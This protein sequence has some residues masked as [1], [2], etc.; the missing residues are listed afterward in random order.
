MKTSGLSSSNRKSEL[1]CPIR[2]QT[3]AAT[4]EEEVR[5]SLIQQMSCE[6]NYPTSL[7]SV[8][9]TLGDLPHIQSQNLPKR[10]ADIICF[11]KSIH[12]QYDLYPLLLIECKAVA[13]TPK[14]INQVTGYNRFIGAYF[15]AVANQQEVRIGWLDPENKSYKFIQGLPNYADLHAA[16]KASFQVIA[17]SI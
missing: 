9:K 10:R 13:L 14:V 11:G 3:V 2:K 1:Y 5:Q 16:A 6:L 4:P 8:E 7:L 17:H 12:S 15:V